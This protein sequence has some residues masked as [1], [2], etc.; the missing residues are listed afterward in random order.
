MFRFKC[1]LLALS[2]LNLPVVYAGFDEGVEAANNGNHRL[3]IEIWSEAAKNG[4][5]KSQHILGVFYQTGITGFIEQDCIKSF[6]L[7][8]KAANQGYQEAEFSLGVAYHKGCGVEKNIALA[9]KW[10]EISANKGDSVSQFN[11]GALHYEEKNYTQAIYWYKKSANGGDAKALNNLG[12]MYG[13]GLG[14]KK[15]KEIELALYILAASNGEVENRDNAL[16]MLANDSI[17]N[18]VRLAK[19]MKETGVLQALDKFAAEKQ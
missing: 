6:D 18:A 9:I 17:K 19:N 14:V 8:N 12:Q 10:Y 11:L 13:R 15:D 7:I 2:A 3:A 1:I 5:A 4:D 16:S